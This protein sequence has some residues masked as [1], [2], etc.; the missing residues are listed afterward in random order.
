MSSIG[1]ILSNARSAILANQTAIQ[2]AS[3]NIGNAQTEGYS[4]QR[5]LLSTSHPQRFG[6]MWLGTGVNATDV[7]R[8]RDQYLDLS[9]RRETANA[10]GFAARREIL[11]QAQEVFGE[12]SESGLAATMDAFWS[13]WSDLANSPDSSGARSLVRQRGQ[14]VVLT[15][16][17]YDRRLAELEDV[18]AL[19][20][21]SQVSELNSLLGRVAELNG[22]I[23]TAEA[24]GGTASDLQDARDLAIEQ[25]SKLADIRVL[26]RNDG[27]IGIALGTM[28]VVDGNHARPVS[29][30]I[31]RGD[32]GRLLSATVDVGSTT[33]LDPGSALAG[34][35]DGIADVR[36]AREHLDALARHITDQVNSFHNTDPLFRD[37]FHNDP[38]GVTAANIRLSDDITESAVN[39]L[40]GPSGTDNSIALGI[41][42]LRDAKFPLTDALGDPILDR[43]GNPVE[44]SL[45]GFYQDL[46][47]DLAF[48]AQDADR[49]AAAAEILVNQVQT[50]RDSVSGVSI[51]EEL[52]Q[53]MRHQQAY[54]AATRLV[55]AA[56]E[57]LQSLLAMV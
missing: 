17:S 29:L 28:N 24:G 41:A 34:A 6:N 26:P 11:M 15:L 46:V 40:A 50:R 48:R 27:T 21:E 14:Q 25:A 49:A 47:T 39:I 30:T 19:R 1:G 42:G 18:T 51:D 52:I 56:D 9:V 8:V 7:I 54:A 2:V 23:I 36:E 45:G 35:L 38:N 33:I 55:S 20:L 3:H 5:P 37:F 4:R 57:M 53:L 16:N 43:D 31:D 13:S 22:R 44:N 10:S 12:P 32:A